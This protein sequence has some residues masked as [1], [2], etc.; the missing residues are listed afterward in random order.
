MSV[1]GGLQGLLLVLAWTGGLVMAAIVLDEW[2]VLGAYLRRVRRAHRAG[3]GS[4]AC[5]ARVDEDDAGDPP[6][7][8]A[9]LIAAHNEAA[10]IEGLVRSI[11]GLRYPSAWVETWVVADRCS[12]QTAARA[13]AAG[14]EV[15]ERGVEPLAPDL[16]V[17]KGPA[18]ND[19][20]AHHRSR[21][22]EM[23]VFII[24]DADVR[25]DPHYLSAM[26]KVYRQGYPVVQGTSMTRDSQG[27]AL[28]DVAAF[29]N[30]AQH[31]VQQ[32]R[33]ALGWPNLII[34]NTLLMGRSV[35][36]ALHWRCAWTSPTEE[37]VKVRLI[38]KGVRIGYACD[39]WVFEEA[40]SDMDALAAQ[41]SRWVRD[42]VVFWARFGVPMMVR[43]LVRRRWRQAEAVLAH[44]WMCSH[45]VELMAS[46]GLVVVA[47]ASGS[48]PAW[49][50]ALGVAGLKLGHAIA[51]AWA[52]GLR[53]R[54][55]WRL[56]CRL[57][58]LAIGWVWGTWRFALKPK[59][60]DWRHTRHRGE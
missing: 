10:C 20:L 56:A 16:P 52:T 47:V 1:L 11:Q 35:W 23:D 28:S 51:L 6:L 30:R 50:W 22:G 40:V 36:E 25:L 54:G 45:T 4:G 19:L 38:R 39:A 18:L 34:G 21:R 12:D 24:L 15:W 59:I 49:C 8:V 57:P 46:A 32:G 33:M 58:R 17:G 9:F 14:A 13:R 55:W 53:G 26:L 44:F 3:P 37:E 31:V 60:K 41:R 27:P 7:R 48:T 2:W 5:L 42:H 29:A 43:A